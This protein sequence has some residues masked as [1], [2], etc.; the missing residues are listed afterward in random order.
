M[1][2]TVLHPVKK[3]DRHE[4]SRCHNQE[5][6]L[7]GEPVSL[8]LPA[9]LAPYSLSRAVARCCHAAAGVHLFAAVLAVT[10]VQVAEPALLLWPALFAVL[11]MLVLLR[12]LSRQ[13]TLFNLVAYL[14]VGAACTFWYALVFLSQRNAL[15]TADAYVVDFLAVAL[16]LAG[17]AGPRPLY[18]LLGSTL[19]L[20][21]GQATTALAAAQAGLPQPL[22]PAPFICYVLMATTLVSL[23]VTGQGN[24]AV[25]P[26]LH[27]A[28]RDERISRVR[29][30]ME[31]KAAALMHD[32]V[33]NHLGAVAAAAPGPLIDGLRDQVERDLQTLVGEE[34]LREE[35]VVP[36][37]RGS[38]RGPLDAAIAEGRRLG[39]D[40]RFSGDPTVLE[41]LDSERATALGLAVSQCL[42]NVAKHAGT[43]VAEVV[44]YDSDTD[45]TAM[46][47]DGG[48]GFVPE[49][50]AADRLG[51]RHSVRGRV[52]AVGGTVEVWSTPGRGTSVLIT[53]PA[54]RARTAEV[55]R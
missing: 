37:T 39:L 35:A 46:V 52:Q 27:R 14:A 10:A 4:A 30:D 3:G 51:L 33:L 36:A 9:H 50:T 25:S 24:R 53:I 13:R 32:T 21:L 28:E 34:W 49:S 26:N 16:V 6:R 47:V 15:S 41:R 22:D 44:V 18:A 40:V 7:E 23:I 1:R 5:V 20:A 17:G 38:R 31:V 43:D 48:R 12:R 11:P 55:R 54:T 2:S 29:Y 42:V 19:G 8:G 45:V